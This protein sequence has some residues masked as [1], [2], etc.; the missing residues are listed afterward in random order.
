MKALTKYLS[1]E[2]IV[3][4]AFLA[5]SDM[6]LMPQDFP[7]AYHTI[8]TALVDGK[9][10][11]K[12]ID[13]RVLKVLQ[14]KEKVNL[15]RQRTIMMPTME[16]LHSSSAKELKR[17]LYKNAVA[18]ARNDH[19]L[20]PLSD[21][22]QESIAYVQLGDAPSPHF[23]DQLNQKFSVKPF[24]FSMEGD[25][26]NDQKRFFE[27]IDNF[28][29]IIVAVYPADPRR[30]EKIR[31]LKE[32]ELEAELKHFRVHGIPQS[33][34]PLIKKLENHQEKMILSYFGNPFGQHFFDGF[35]TMIMAYEDDPD[36]QQASIEI[37]IGIGV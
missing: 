25:H 4:K 32:K 14:F 37:L 30:I 24:I 2:E 13:E 1:D 26:T 3:L 10:T 27:Q 29:L 18:L 7:K 31:L 5:G 12:D 15:D 21:S 8:K 20:V 16:A 28:S 34:L 36:A 22:K 17:L 6:L 9:I 35:S 23:L 11:D 19:H 33:F